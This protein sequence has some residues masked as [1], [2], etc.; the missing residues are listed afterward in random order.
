MLRVEADQMTKDTKPM[1]MISADVI[2]SNC[3]TLWLKPLD[4]IKQGVN[5][6][7]MKAISTA[8][9]K[10]LNGTKGN[11][12]PLT[13]SSHTITIPMSRQTNAPTF[14]KPVKILI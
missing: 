9:T 14:R 7:L 4:S 10:A 5:D 13:N 6:R 8:R 3:H 11:R 2:R 12:P 1:T